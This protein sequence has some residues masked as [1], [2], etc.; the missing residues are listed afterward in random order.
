MEAKKFH[1]LLSA[2]WRIRKDDDIIQSESE[3]PRIRELMLRP[4][5]NQERQSP[6]AGDGGCLSSRREK[7]KVPF[8]HFLFRLGSWQLSGWCRLPLGRVICFTHSADSNANLFWRRRAAGFESGL[9]GSEVSAIRYY[10]LT[11]SWQ[12]FLNKPESSYLKRIIEDHSWCIH[13]CNIHTYTHGIQMPEAKGFLVWI[14]LH[15]LVC[16]CFNFSNPEQI[17]CHMEQNVSKMITTISPI[18]HT[19]CLY[20]KEENMKTNIYMYIYICTYV[21]YIY[22]HTHICMYNWITLL[23]NRN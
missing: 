1:D 13:T 2:S 10:T 22:I 3:G 4:D 20:F 7:A 16:V 17:C 23:Y 12:R 5:P 18:Q 15:L 9:S 14:L 8:L 11:N 6:R 21:I 19:L